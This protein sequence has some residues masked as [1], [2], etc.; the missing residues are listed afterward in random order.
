VSIW[1]VGTKPVICTS[2]DGEEVTDREETTESRIN[3]VFLQPTNRQQGPGIVFTHRDGVD[4]ASDFDYRISAAKNVHRMMKFSIGDH[5]LAIPL[6][7]LLMV[8][9]ISQSRID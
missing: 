9:S 8:S 7:I 2:N 5:D 4:L 1:T 6:M 3:A